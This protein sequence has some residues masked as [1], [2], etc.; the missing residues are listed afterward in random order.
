MT[1][2]L[3]VA[4]FLEGDQTVVGLVGTRIAAS[5]LPQNSLSPAIVYETVDVIPDPNLNYADGRD[6]L[7]ARM[8]ITVIATT[9]PV[10]KSIHAAIRNA[11][12]HKYLVTVATKTVRSSRL[13]LVGPLDRDNEAGLW[14]QPADY[15]IAY[16]E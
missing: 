16:Y 7:K 15:L 11:M 14:V 13:S 12:D 5:Q 8:Q 2:E 9:I 3:I 1:P 10:L 4:G 6:L